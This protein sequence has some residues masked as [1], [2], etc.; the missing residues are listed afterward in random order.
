MLGFGEKHRHGS[1]FHPDPHLLAEWCGAN[2]LT[3][4]RI[5]DFPSVNTPIVGSASYG[6]GKDWMR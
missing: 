4:L 3:S 1:Q 5:S 6:S 2:Y